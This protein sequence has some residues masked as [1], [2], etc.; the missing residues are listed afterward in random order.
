M[1]QRKEQQRKFAAIKTQL[2]L[3][4]K[5]QLISKTLYEKI[6]VCQR[7]QSQVAIAAEVNVHSKPFTVHVHVYRVQVHPGHFQRFPVEPVLA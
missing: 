7:K 6:K 3:E 1:V 4:P 2:Y 5:L